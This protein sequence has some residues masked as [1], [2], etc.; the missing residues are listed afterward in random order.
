MKI[1]ITGM[2][3][4]HCEMAVRKTLSNVEGVISVV[5]VDRIHGE[6]IIE[7]SPDPLLVVAAV[8]KSGYVAEVVR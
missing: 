8:A 5:S 4:P 3:C 1:T 2:T 6:A 7:G